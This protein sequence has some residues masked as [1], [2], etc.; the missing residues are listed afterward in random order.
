MILFAVLLESSVGASGYREVGSVDVMSD[1][2]VSAE[3]VI[4]YCCDNGEVV[5]SSDCDKTLPMASTTKIM[6]AVVAIDNAEIND[7]VRVDASACGVEGSSVYLYKNERITIKD[8]LYAVMLESANDAA[9]AL[10][11]AVC[12]DLESFVGM[13]NAK[14]AELGMKNTSY[15]NPHGLDEEGHYSTARDLALLMSY[16]MKDPVFAQI[17]GTYRYS[18]EM[19]DAEAARMFINHNRLL[20]SCEGVCGGK[21]GYTKTS[22]RCLVSVAVRD[23]VMLCA[24]TLNDPNDWKDHS[25]LYDAGFSV[26]G[27]Y[28]FD[29]Q[30]VVIPVINGVSSTVGGR[31]EGISVVVKKEDADRISIVYEHDRFIYAD[32]KKGELLGRIVYTVDGVR[33]GCSEIVAAEDVEAIKYKNFFEKIISIFIRD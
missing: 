2:S 24:V 7:E 9:A 13:M 32:I 18:C 8:L 26:Y 12:G 33:V 10:A 21:T 31:A 23:G 30:T 19:K 20:N 5:Y 29:A 28:D 1:V 4:L 25:S 11:V 14:A 16:A 3:A 17:T 6:T 22:G 15:R 27:R